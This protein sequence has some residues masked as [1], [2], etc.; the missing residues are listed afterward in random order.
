[1][2][3]QQ[4]GIANEQKHAVLVSSPHAGHALHAQHLDEY[5]ERAGITIASHLQ[6]TEL[7]HAQPQGAYWREQGYDLAI[8]AG[9]DGTIGSVATHLNGSGIPLGILP[10]GTANDVARSLHLPIA[11]EAACAALAGAIPL[12][13]DIGQVLPGLTEPGAYSAAH[14]AA[15]HP[16]EPSP[17][18]GV[19]FLHA[20]T[21]GLNVEFS[22]LATDA[23][24]RQRLGSLTYAA[25]ALEAVTRYHPV[26]VTLHLIGIEGESEASEKVFRGHVV[27]VCAV[28]MP[29]FGGRIGARLPGVG[30]RDRQ[31]DFL[32]IE[33][34]DP[35]RL[36]H[37]VQ[38]LLATISGA[39]GNANHVAP[40]EQDDETWLLPG[41]YR[42]RAR[43]AF[44]E[45]N[46]AVDV[47]LD[48]EIRTHTPAVV[49]VA[50]NQ[51]RVLVSPEAKYQL[52]RERELD[53]P[54][55]P[56]R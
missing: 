9:G 21:L 1:M 22:R 52:M 38:Q 41:V 4:P 40:A 10:L 33:A 56:A 30:L 6:I 20:V 2:A 35:Q 34:A 46:D 54:N 47:T 55:A 48:G 18:A 27:Q 17:V 39:Q 5:L 14:S 31:L 37:V 42:F 49:R 15:A 11:V 24:R 28:N 51:L 8:A 36:R 50:P 19:C 23:L 26:D 45:T 44:I 32:V 25:S 29:V 12:D 13:V 16:G 43:A 53:D 3:A 7:D